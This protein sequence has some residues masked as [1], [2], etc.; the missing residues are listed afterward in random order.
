LWL[1]VYLQTRLHYGP[2]N[3]Q[4][5]Q[6]WLQHTLAGTSS[7]RLE[8]KSAPLISFGGKTT[9]AGALISSSAAM[10]SPFTAD[11]AIISNPEYS[12]DDG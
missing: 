11:G 12:R 8:H 7:L 1:S 6:E 4:S 5:S 3:L 9:P 2:R 10:A